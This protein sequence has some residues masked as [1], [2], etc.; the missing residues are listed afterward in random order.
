ML[1]IILMG[2][3]SLAVAIFAIQNAVSVEISFCSGTLP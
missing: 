1:Y 2:I 3:I